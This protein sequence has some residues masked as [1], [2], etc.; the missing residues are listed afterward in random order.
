[1]AGPGV[2]ED[3][4]PQPRTR[5]PVRADRRGLSD[6]PGAAG[7]HRLHPRGVRGA[8]AGSDRAVA[9]APHRGPDRLPGARGRNRWP[10]P[11]RKRGGAGR[12]ETEYTISIDAEYLAGQR[13]PYQEDMSLVED[14][15]LL[16]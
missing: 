14:I 5:G 8:D 15:D 9:R 7:R 2:R 13:F 16:A 12:S 1:D 4:R 3:R 11:P 10:G 6:G